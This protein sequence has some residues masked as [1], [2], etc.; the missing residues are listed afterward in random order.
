[1]Q[2]ILVFFL[3]F[4]DALSH[5][6]PKN[7]NHV[8]QPFQSKPFV[9][10]THKFGMSMSPVFASLGMKLAQNGSSKEWAMKLSFAQS[11]TWMESELFMLNNLIEL[12]TQI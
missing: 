4:E 11:L 3:Y 2:Q 1:M 10:L 7:L 9:L 5:L 12:H 8:R 6:L